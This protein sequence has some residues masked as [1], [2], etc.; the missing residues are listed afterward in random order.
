MKQAF[1][2]IQYEKTIRDAFLKALGER[3]SS[4][5]DFKTEL[6]NRDP[7][8]TVTTQG[9]EKAFQAG[10]EFELLAAIAIK[11]FTLEG[12]NPSP[13]KNCPWQSS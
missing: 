11:R 4:Q 13:T 10:R 2:F 3:L 5:P 1:N 8:G 9:M 12:S 7:S 6:Q